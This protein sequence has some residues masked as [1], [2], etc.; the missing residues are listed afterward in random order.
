MRGPHG[1]RGA[2]GKPGAIPVRSRRQPHQRYGQAYSEDTPRGKQD[3]QNH[4]GHSSSRVE[5]QLGE[6]ETETSERTGGQEDSKRIE[7]LP[8]RQAS[9]RGSRATLERS[10]GPADES[11]QE[12]AAAA[13][14][15]QPCGDDGIQRLA[16]GFLEWA[17]QP[18][19]ML[20]LH[21]PSLPHY[22]FGSM[23]GLRR[24]AKL[25]QAELYLGRFPL[26]RP[27]LLVCQQLCQ[28]PNSTS[29]AAT[30]PLHIQP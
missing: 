16:Y 15:P 5:V 14:R 26:V 28:Q 11:Y 8:N 21:P 22:V 20:V 1:F 13:A 4:P 17:G 6:R 19:C 10:G 12:L 30:V 2:V 9:Q 7:A 24:A 18:R 25:W 3:I 29:I 27:Q 23:G